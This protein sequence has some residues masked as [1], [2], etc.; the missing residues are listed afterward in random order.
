MSQPS[1]VGFQ[2]IYVPIDERAGMEDALCAN[3]LKLLDGECSANNHFRA[4]WK[5]KYPE[6]LFRT[7]QFRL[8]RRYKNHFDGEDRVMPWKGSPAVVFFSDKINQL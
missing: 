5:F 3:A 4:T 2:C 6:E 8:A 7:F 1:I